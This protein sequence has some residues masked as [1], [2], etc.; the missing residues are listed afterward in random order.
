MNFKQIIGVGLV[1]T[2]INGKVFTN[3]RNSQIGGQIVWPKQV[4]SQRANQACKTN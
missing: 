4:R 1:A 3:P 2:L